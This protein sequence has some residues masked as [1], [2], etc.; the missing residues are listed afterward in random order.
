MIDVMIR[1]LFPRYILA[2]KNGYAMAKAIEKGLHIMCDIV[3]N[4]LD[5]ALD[6]E[7]MP[8]WRLDEKAWELGCPYDYSADVES[9]RRWIRDAYPMF[10]QY[11][12]PQAIYSYLEGYFDAVEVEENWQ[13]GGKPYHFR[14]NVAGEWTEANEKWARMAIGTAQNV[15]SVLDGVTI[16]Q[17]DSLVF[18]DCEPD[19]FRTPCMICSDNLICGE[20]GG[21][22]T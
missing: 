7:K 22:G 1:N 11:G 3:Q 14:V 16:Y 4:G 9:K 12:T 19:I 2:D 15:R 5:I 6:V 8:E 10:A 17:T 13:Y 20:N 21:D 18:A